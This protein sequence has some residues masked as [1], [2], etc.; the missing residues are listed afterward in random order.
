[1]PSTTSTIAWFSD[2]G[3]ADR[4]GGRQECLPRRN[5]PNPHFGRGTRTRWLRDTDAY[6]QFI[7]DGGLAETIN[8]QLAGLD[9]DDVEQLA[10]VGRTIR[11]AVTG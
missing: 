10:T 3:L 6:H 4:P 7:D 2:L 9:T 8:A 5:D 1:M 11:D